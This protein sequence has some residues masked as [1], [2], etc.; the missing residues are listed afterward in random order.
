MAVAATTELEAINI[1]LAAIGEAPVNTLTGLLPVD[2]KIAQSTLVEINKSVQ[3]E[4]WSFNTE[5]DVTLTRN[6]SKQIVLPVNVLRIDAN[7][8]QHPDIDPIQRGLKLYDRLKNTFEFDEDLIC[9][10]VY[11]R[12][13]D[14]IPEQA[15]SYINIRAA[16]IFVDRL[17]SDQGLRTYTKE[18]EIRARVTLTETDLAN[19]DHNILRGDPSLTTVFGTYSPANGLIR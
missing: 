18:D 12:D 17:V 3:A 15:R 7:I 9:T 16:R 5:I 13:F 1:M 8:H 2:V 6:A 19:G 10:V 4:G 11:F 14:E